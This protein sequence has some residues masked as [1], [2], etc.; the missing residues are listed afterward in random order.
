MELKKINKKK[1]VR[2]HFRIIADLA[3]A[4]EVTKNAVAIPAATIDRIII[5]AAY[6]YDTNVKTNINLRGWE[7]LS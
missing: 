3:A 6:T 2:T 7:I 1:Q 5:T 4:D